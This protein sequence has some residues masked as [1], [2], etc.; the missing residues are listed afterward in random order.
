MEEKN[1]PARDRIW[2]SEPIGITEAANCK[3][4]QDCIYQH[5]DP[6]HAY[7]DDYKKIVCMIYSA[8]RHI[9]KPD[10]VL[11]EGADCEYFESM[12]EFLKNHP[13]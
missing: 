4:C 5:P 2:G 3:A 7:Q 6:E 9:M 8:E 11:F 13:D 10:D 12:S 1:N